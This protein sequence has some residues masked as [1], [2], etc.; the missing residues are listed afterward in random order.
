MAE[1]AYT[2]LERYSG[3]TFSRVRPNDRLCDLQWTSV[4]WF[5]WELKL[6]NDFY[7]RFGIDL[8]DCLGKLMPATIGDIVIFLNQ[9]WLSR[10]PNFDD[11][12]STF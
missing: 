6:C 1:F 4:C 8:S 9:Q 2:Y 12:P 3:I 5:D 10:K 7:G 11:K